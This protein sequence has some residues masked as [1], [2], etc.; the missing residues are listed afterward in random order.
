[1]TTTT[2]KKVAYSYR[3]FSTPRQMNGDSLRR[4]TKAARDY[5]TAHNLH[6]DENFSFEDL[7]TSAFRSKNSEQGKL[8]DF[9][10]AVEQGAI[11]SDC[12]L[13]VENLDRI[14][15][16]AAYRAAATLNDIVQLGVTL[17]TLDDQRVIN[18]A[19]LTENPF[20]FVEIVIKFIRANEESVRKSS[21]TRA[22]W[23]GKRAKAATDRK[24]MT[25]RCPG[26]LKLDEDSN[27]Y[28][29][30]PDRAALI[31]RMFDMVVGGQGLHKIAETFNRENIEPFGDGS[32]RR[33]AYW[34]RSYIKKIT[35][36][37]AVIG[38]FVPHHTITDEAGRRCRVPLDAIPD[39]FPRVVDPAAFAQ[40][41]SMRLSGR[42]APRVRSNGL[43]NVFAGL[44]TCHR[45]GGSMTRVNKGSGAK[46]GHPYLICSSAKV[47][48]GCRYEAVR[49]DRLEEALAWDAAVLAGTV[50]SGCADT[51]AKVREIERDVSRRSARVRK[52]VDALL[53]G[54]S[55]ALAARLAEEEAGLAVANDE[56]RVAMQL[57]SATT[58]LLVRS[59]LERLR[60]QVREVPLPIGEINAILRQCFQ[61]VVIDT[62][63]GVM[64]FRWKQ[65]GEALIRFRLVTGVQVPVAFWTAK[66]GSMRPISEGVFLGLSAHGECPEV[67][68]SVSGV[69]A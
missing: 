41:Q 54:D 6:L 17:V 30:I 42:A 10:S 22:N 23:E 28:V 68:S 33:A 13:L 60:E 16:D 44:A 26:W 57:A 9:M 4:Q 64:R 50:P 12:Y 61:S 27:N 55:R 32:W 34:H 53:L 69:R 7:G 47:G 19:A 37:P 43:Q 46:G 36:N 21:L 51:E 52:L 24:P 40:V 56:L 29:V 63:A 25:S 65:G 62:N 45:C 66:D 31:R 14:S 20:L 2:P 15:R 38:T 11:P 3:R 58:P 48:A 59:R 67:A 35:E 49:L 1:M 18:R 8:K 39:Y 5:A